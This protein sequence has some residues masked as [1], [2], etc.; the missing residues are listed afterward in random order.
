M[1]GVAERAASAA[2]AT[3]LPVLLVELVEGEW[4]AE[5]VLA[6]WSALLSSAAMDAAIS[7]LAKLTAEPGK[8]VDESRQKLLAELA[9][10]LLDQCQ[11]EALETL[12]QASGSSLQLYA[13]C[14]HS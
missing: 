3:A 2:S 9:G 10:A 5:A 11:G 14:L 8:E 6:V 1:L 7:T 4:P 12:E 13:I